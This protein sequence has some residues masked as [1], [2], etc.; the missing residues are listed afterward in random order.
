[1]GSFLNVCIYRIPRDL[2]VVF[3]RSFC[4]ECGRQIGWRDNIPVLSYVFLSGRCRACR[5][6]IGVRYPLVELSTA[7][8]FAGVALRYG[9]SGAAAK[10]AVFESLMTILFWTDLEERILPDELT[11]GGAIL[12]LI[13][14]FFVPLPD[15]MADFLPAGMALVWKSVLSATVAGVSFGLLFWGLARLYARIRKREGLGLG[16]VKL[17]ILLGA[18]F[19]LENGILVLLIGT[20]T[21]ALLGSAE[22]LIRRREIGTHELP[23]G[24]FLCLGAAIVPLF[25]RLAP[26]T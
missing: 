22:A 24:S 5:K 11:I 3:P 7:L 21:G 14:A 6:P 16:D 2:S 12:G 20:L 13:F 10:W 18:F 25:H 26:S 8:L 1:M 15:L 23:F 17:L 9:V 4:P 19:G